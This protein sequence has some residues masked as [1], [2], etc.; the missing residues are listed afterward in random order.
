[1]K[2]KFWGVRG[3]IASP[4]N[5]K[6]VE[7]KIREVLKLASPADILSPESIDRF[8]QTLPYSLKGTYGGNTTCI[9][10]ITEEDQTIIIDAGTGL[11]QLGKS[12][13]DNGK[14][15]GKGEISIFLSHSHWDH[16]QGLMFFLP[17]YF[18]GNK[19][20]FYS[21]VENLEERLRYQQIKTHFPLTLD[22]MAA[23]KIFNHFPEGV[24][25]ELYGLEFTSKAV[26]HP[27]GCFSYKFTQPDGK[28]FVFCSDAEFS[29]ETMDNI[30][31]YIEYFRNADVLVFDTQY[32]FEESLQKIDWGHSSAAIATDIAIKSNVKKL[33]LFHHEPFYDDAKMDLVTINAFKYKDMTAPS[34][35]LKIETAYEGMEIDI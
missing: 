13:V 29:I 34:H 26:R 5:G 6:M 28:S 7:Q 17:I 11:R 4:I 14:M 32:T 20:K 30:E 21:S 3:S 24:T 19:I 10:L 31:A 1:M 15:T 2:I 16:I 23:D 27:G 35:F 12:L 9:E 8:L 18:K 33:I 22:E 25:E